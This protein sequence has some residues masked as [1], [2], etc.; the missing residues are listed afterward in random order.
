MW[1][2][3]VVSLALWIVIAI[4]ELLRWCLL[5]GVVVAS[6]RHAWRWHNWSALRCHAVEVLRILHGLKSVVGVL[7]AVVGEVLD[8]AK[9]IVVVLVG[10]GLG[11]QVHGVLPDSLLVQDV[12]HLKGVHAHVGTLVNQNVLSALLEQV[13]LLVWVYLAS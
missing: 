4:V 9:L 5:L 11:E 1:F 6:R 3:E 13:H 12:L 10:D 2:S 8:H 7:L